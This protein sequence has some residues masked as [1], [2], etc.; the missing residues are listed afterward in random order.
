MKLIEKITESIIA[1]KKK[2]IV[3]GAGKSAIEFIRENCL[4]NKEFPF[5]EF[6]CDNN[7]SLWNTK[8]E[9]IT[10]VDPKI[11]LDERPDECVIVIGAALPYSVMSD[12]ILKHQCHYYCI[13]TIS[14]IKSFLFYQ[15]NKDKLL[16]VVSLFDDKKSREHFKKYF[17]IMISSP[18]SFNE[19]YTS[20][21]YW[22]NDL[23]GKLK[24]GEVVVYAGA[25]DGKHID[26]AINSNKNAVVHGFEPNKPFAERLQKKYSSMDKVHIHNYALYDTETTLCFDSSVE[27]SARIISQTEVGENNYQTVNTIPLDKAINGKVD[28]ISLDVEGAEL[29]ALEGARRI[30]SEYA[31]SLA[32][33]SYHNLKDYIEIPL[34]IKENFKDYKLYFRHHSPS[35]CESVVYAIK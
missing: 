15:Q 5:P 35:F 2:W 22:E 10:V 26:R 9:G 6:I 4:N 28:L 17:E 20:N 14:Q 32:V 8:I 11:I 24:D 7:S 31:P 21:A 30:I 3:Y 18:F 25:Y 12:L 19:I 16:G 33:C 29:K 1:H 23:K 34:W 13:I 27:L